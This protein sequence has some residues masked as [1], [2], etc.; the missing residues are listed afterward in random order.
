M[1]TPSTTSPLLREVHPRNATCT[2][3]TFAAIAARPLSVRLTFSTVSLI[4]QV[5]GGPWRVLEVFPLGV[6]PGPATPA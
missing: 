3:A 1:A 4:E 6:G 2:D 5:D